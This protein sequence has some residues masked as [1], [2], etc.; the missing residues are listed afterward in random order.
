M[1]AC[2]AADWRIMI[3]P[4]P[5]H[6]RAFNYPR[7]GGVSRAAKGADCK[8]S[9]FTFCINGHSEKNRQILLNHINSLGGISECRRRAL[10]A[11]RCVTCPG[12]SASQ[13][14]ETRGVP[15]AISHWP[16]S[17]SGISGKDAVRV[18]EDMANRGPVQV[19]ASD[20]VQRHWPLLCRLPAPN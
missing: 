17:E 5:K 12:S 14:L 16:A 6:L 19:A 1:I 2:Y 11:A 13:P 10:L 7:N 20:D 4:L 9:Y 3:K 8:S 18:A 15:A